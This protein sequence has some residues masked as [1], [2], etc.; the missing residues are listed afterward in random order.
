MYLSQSEEKILRGDR[1]WAL[2]KAMKLIVTLGELGDAEKLVSIRKAQISGVSYKTVGDSNLEL[3]EMLAKE[4]IKT[5]IN[6]TLNPAGMDLDRWEEMGIPQF[7]A[8]KQLRICN[9]YEKLGIK[10]TCTCTPYLSGNKPSFGEMVGF[11]ESSAIAYVNSVL[12]AKTNRHGGLDALSA[13]LIGKVPLMGYLLHENR[14]ANLFVNVKFK[15]KN[16][17]DYAA[18]G[19]FIGK[20]TQA[21]DV[22]VFNGLANATPDNLKLLAAASAASGAIALFHVLGVTPEIKRIEKGGITRRLSTIEVTSEVIKSIYDELSANT[23]PNLIAIGC[24]HCSLKEIK[25]IAYMLAGRMIREKMKFWVFTS[26][27]VFSKAEKKGY[28]NMIKTSGGDVFKHTCMVVAPIEEMGFECVLT[29]SAKAS[30]YIP[31]LTKNRCQAGLH[32][33]LDCVRLATNK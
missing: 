28:I 13:A 2:A 29:N 17:A 31:R 20:S 22:P 16:E 25:T 5:K 30:F 8:K 24:P 10:R 6:A 26:P 21:D 33:L 15:P 3:L 11:S 14:R 9:A 32:S 19:Y 4:K 7:F 27:Q 1:G 18:L 23:K 12:G